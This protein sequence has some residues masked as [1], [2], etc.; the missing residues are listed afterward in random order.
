MKGGRKMYKSPDGWYQYTETWSVRTLYNMMSRGQLDFDWDKQRGYVWNNNKA[1]LFIHS[2]FWGMLENTETFHFTNHG[3][4]YLCTDGK[5]RGLSILKYINNEYALIGL[6]NSYDI[7]LLNGETFQVNGKY[8]KQLPQE[9]QD[10]IWDMQINIAV[11]ENATPDV[12]AEMFARMNNG[13]AVSRTDIAIAKNDSSIQFDELGKHEIFTA[14]LRKKEIESKKYR[15]IIVK[16]Y[17]ALTSDKPN[18]KSANVHKLESDLRLSDGD[19]ELITTLYD[20]LLETYKYIVLIEDN[21]G[22]KMF[23]NDFMYYY[24]PYIHMFNNNFEKLAQW[25]NSFYKNVPDEYN[26]IVG[27]SADSVNTVNKMNIIKDSIERFLEND[28]VTNG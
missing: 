7:Y 24:I 14:F 17:I 3:K 12:E 1:S 20:N 18:Y 9:L 22:K 8:F 23:N 27:F 15:T 10:K 11:L 21:I 2:I 13:Q 6:K 25:I 26:N 4:Q 5:Q 19:I 16:T 28:S